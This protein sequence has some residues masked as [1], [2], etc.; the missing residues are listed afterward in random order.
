MRGDFSGAEFFFQK[1]ARGEKSRSGKFGNFCGRVGDG[2]FQSA[3]RGGKWNREKN[4]FA[5]FLFAAFHGK[6]LPDFFR[7]MSPRFSLFNFFTNLAPKV[8]G[9]FFGTAVSLLIFFAFSGTIA[10]EINFTFSKFAIAAMVFGGG[11][12]GNSAAVFLTTFAEPEKFAAKGKV[13][14]AAVGA[15]GLLF[16]AVAPLFFVAENLLELSGFFF[17]ISAAAALIFAE[18]FSTAISPGKIA[19]IFV[20]LIL[21]ICFFATVQLPILIFFFS[22]PFS[23]TVFALAG[24]AGEIFKI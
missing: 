24:F 17:A 11:L 9:G 6:I 8:A 12:L 21:L 13:C 14:A 19:G 4:C 18:I 20:G 5:G 10:G 7:K 15:T 1:P 2:N 22:I 16:A 23:Y 3:A